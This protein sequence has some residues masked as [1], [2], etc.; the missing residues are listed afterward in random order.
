MIKVKLS[1]I[2]NNKPYYEI[3]DKKGRTYYATEPERAV[4]IANEIR[5]N[6]E[7]INIESI[8]QILDKHN[9]LIELVNSLN[10][11][12]NEQEKRK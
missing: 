10:K 7:K 11:R 2:Y 3:K 4:E 9:R 8:D 12:K 6:R 5:K 1:Q